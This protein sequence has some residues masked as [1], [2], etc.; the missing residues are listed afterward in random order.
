FLTTYAGVRLIWNI[1]AATIVVGH[2]L[3]VTLA[4][5]IALNTCGPK[6]RRAEF[7][8]AIAMVA[9]TLF[10]L[11]LLSTPTAGLS[12]GELMAAT[13]S[14]EQIA[15]YGRNGAVYLPGLFADWV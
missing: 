7:P 15:D 2:V 14:D 9:Y 8:I 13:L 1:E 10:G 4:H 3:A 11:W 6:A 5:A 12:P